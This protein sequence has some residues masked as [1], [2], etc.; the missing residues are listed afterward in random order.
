MAINANSE[1]LYKFLTG[2][3]VVDSTTNGH[4][5]TNTG[6]VPEGVIGPKGDISAV[7]FTSGKRF[8]NASVRAAL[9]GSTTWGIEFLM[10]INQEML[11]AQGVFYSIGPSGADG[12]VFRVLNDG[13]FRVVLDNTAFDSAAGMFVEGNQYYVVVT[14]DGTDIKA[15]ADKA[16]N[17]VGTNVIDSPATTAQGS[18]PSSG[19]MFIGAFGPTPTSFIPDGWVVNEVRIQNTTPTTF[20][21]LDTGPTPVIGTPTSTT[22]PITWVDQTGITLYEILIFTSDVPASATVV[23]LVA[24]AVQAFTIPGLASSTQFF[25]YIRGIEVTTQD[26]LMTAISASDSA[27]TSTVTPVPPPDA[28]TGLVVTSQSG[29][30]VALSWTNGANTTS[31]EIMRAQ[32]SSVGA[33]GAWTKINDASVTGTTY[34]DNAANSTP[35]PV[36]D[37]SYVYSINPLNGSTEG[38]WSN[39]IFATFITEVTRIPGDQEAD[40][41]NEFLQTDD[42]AEDVV[43]TKFGGAPVTIRAMYDAESTEV[44]PETGDI[45]TSNPLVHVATKDV[46]GSS[47]R[48]TFTISGQVFRV[49]EVMPDGSGLSTVVLTKD[50]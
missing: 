2:A 29:T 3:L 47:N 15:F 13:K 27:T 32:I 39:I 20:P 33:A 8:S 5:L 10:F 42:F 24:S 25:V 37:R 40:L 34:I 26:K 31:L 49:R 50:K 38:D 30:A 18:V 21:S 9:S 17:I 45:R 43:Y 23:G 11:T 6:S 46:E 28:P 44:D 48:D 14:Y 1:A 7:G 12:H 41:P 4:T 16:N 22:L 19:S 36:A 35:D